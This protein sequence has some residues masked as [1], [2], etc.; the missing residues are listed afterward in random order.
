M[1]DQTPDPVTDQTPVAVSKE[2]LLKGSM[3]EEWVPIPGK[4]SVRVRGL[5]RGEVFVLQKLRKDNRIDVATDERRTIALCMVEPQ[6]TEAEV[7]QW[8]KGSPAGELEPVAAKIR[9]LSGL[10]DKA[11]KEAMLDFRDEPDE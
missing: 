7:E 3:T 8:Q 5:S 10:Q 4:G 2:Q 11:D 1:A 6:L 9:E